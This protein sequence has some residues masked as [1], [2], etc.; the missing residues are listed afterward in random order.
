MA[1]LWTM[2]AFGL[3]L[4]ALVYVCY[5]LRIFYLGTAQLATGRPI[6]PM[7]ITFALGITTTASIVLGDACALIA[8]VIALAQHQRRLVVIAVLAAISAWVPAIVSGWGFNHVVEVRSLVLS[9]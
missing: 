1:M 7:G 8:A 5:L 6:R 9:K 2:S 4:I 3:S